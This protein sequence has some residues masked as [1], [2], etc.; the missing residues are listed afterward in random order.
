MLGSLDIRDFRCL[1]SVRMQCDPAINIIYG[2]N[3]AGKTSLLEAIYFLGRGR[4]FRSFKREP[5]IRQGAERF[6]VFGRTIAPEHGEQAIGVGFGSDGFRGRINGVDLRALSDLPAALPVQ[7]IDPHVHRLVEGGPADRRQFMDWGLFHVEHGFL[8]T[9]G[10]FSQSLKQRNAGLREGWPDASLIPWESQV[11]ETGEALGRYRQAYIEKLDPL[12]TDVVNSV[13]E[14]KGVTLGYQQ[15]WSADH[16]LH[17]ALARARETDRL[18]G[19]TS[20]GPHRSDMQ[21]RLDGEPAQ[22][23]VSR[24]QEKVIGACLVVAQMMLH[25]RQARGEGVLLIDDV[26]SELDRDHLGRLLG[27]VRDLPVQKFVSVISVD[28]L[29][30]GDW[31]SGKMF[32]VEQGKV[33]EV[34]Q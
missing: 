3:G 17:E 31:A 2:A 21:I 29:T 32:H 5:L 12:F 18:R 7:V 13:L 30:S 24:G 11:A 23:V 19:V 25:T 28:A 15:G 1:Q 26:A 8:E 16:S 33:T 9:W 34:V 6:T 22:A 14:F 27:M 20:K 4:S 10:R